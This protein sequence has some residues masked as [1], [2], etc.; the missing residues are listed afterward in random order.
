MLEIRSEYENMRSSLISIGYSEDDEES[1]KI[2]DAVVAA[3]LTIAEYKLSK[4]SLE[5]VLRFL[6]EDSKM[7]LDAW[8]RSHSDALWRDFD[9]GNTTFGDYVR[10]K[11][12]AYDSESGSRHNGLVGKLTQMSRGRCLVEYIGLAAGNSMTHPMQNLESL[13]MV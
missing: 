1:K 2:L 9:Y 11:K 5:L 13:K 8:A 4:E 7:A 3:S 6:Q 12:D 10:V